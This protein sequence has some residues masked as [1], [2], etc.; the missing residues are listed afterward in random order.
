MKWNV[1][2]IGL[3][4]I[5]W[6]LELDKKRY[7]PCTH[8]GTLKTMR[9]KFCL[10]GV[11]DRNNEKID[12]FLKWWY[13]DTKD[14]SIKAFTNYK[15]LFDFY[16]KNN[17][18]I[19]FIII[20]TGPDS[21]IE[22]LNDAIQYQ[23]RN[24]LIEKPI[25]YHTEQL[26]PIKTYIEKHNINL[27]V[28][29]ERRYHPYY[30]KVKEIIDRNV[31]GKLKHIQGKVLAPA[32]KRDPLLEDAIHWLDLILW[33]VGIPEIL[34]SYRKEN[35]F[36]IEEHS[37]HLLKKDD[38]LIYLESGGKREYFEFIMTLDFEKGR[39]EIGNAGIKIL[40]KSISSRYEKFY[41]LKEIPIKIPFLNPWLNMY[42]FIY[43]QKTPNFNDAYSGILLYERLK[44]YVHLY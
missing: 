40:R 8:A 15:D 4:R 6:Q 41:E 18:N 42:D 34:Y 37:V 35:S 36:R 19:D 2:L 5:G 10:I 22:I 28:N 26:K 29:F 23:I 25:A 24:I 11:C 1:I 31:F 44:Q 3:G 9:D 7:H 30:K 14:S 39:I 38:I 32:I 43:K 12:T 17:Q 20:T 27:Y 33:Y 16:K 21:H 13:Q